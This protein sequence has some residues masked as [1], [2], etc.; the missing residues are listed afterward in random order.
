MK[1]DVFGTQGDFT[2]APEISQMFGELIGIW[3]IATW[4]QM[5]SP[6]SIN[7]VEM[8]PGRGSLMKDFLRAAKQFPQFYEALEVHMVEISPGMLMYN[9]GETYKVAN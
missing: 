1:R 8:G 3:C 5:G 4:Q 9:G 2:T 6:Q 7:I